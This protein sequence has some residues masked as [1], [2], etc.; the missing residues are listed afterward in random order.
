MAQVVQGH[1]LAVDAHCQPAEV[2]LED[3]EIRYRLE[4]EFRLGVI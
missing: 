3:D 1:C 2:S 4:E